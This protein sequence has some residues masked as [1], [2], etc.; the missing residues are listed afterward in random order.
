MKTSNEEFKNL[1]ENVDQLQYEKRTQKR[2]I[3]FSVD[4]K[5][6]LEGKHLTCRV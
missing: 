6:Q 1:K 4:N 2:I 5:Q 3:D